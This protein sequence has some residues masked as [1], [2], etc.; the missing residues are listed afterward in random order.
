MASYQVKCKWDVRVVCFRVEKAMPSIFSFFCQETCIIH[1]TYLSLRAKKLEENKKQNQ[2]HL[3]KSF[4][5][6][7][8]ELCWQ[9]LFSG[10]GCLPQ[11]LSSPSS[12]IGTTQNT[13]LTPN[14]DARKRRKVRRNV[15]KESV[16]Q[17]LNYRLV[18]QE[19]LWTSMQKF[20]NLQKRK[21][22]F[23]EKVNLDGRYSPLQF[24]WHVVPHQLGK[25]HL[26]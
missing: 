25:P 4:K 11:I 13:K 24:A 7:R 12:A 8:I 15:T 20:V 26:S 17:R 1:Y 14:N 23:R 16:Y 19:A 5:F 6:W 18:P 2:N 9:E 21:L 22:I 10:F 3:T